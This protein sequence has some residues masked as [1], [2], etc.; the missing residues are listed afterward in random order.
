MD[1]R[2]IDL[3]EAQV[4]EVYD[5]LQAMMDAISRLRS[6]GSDREQRRTYWAKYF[7]HQAEVNRL[8]PPTGDRP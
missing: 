7:Q 2:N 4:T 8:I 1:D 5:H 3:S 6:A